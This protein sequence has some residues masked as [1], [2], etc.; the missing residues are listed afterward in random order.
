V[1]GAVETVF[2]WENEHCE[3][4]DLPDTPAHAVRTASGVVLFAADAPR[5]FVSVGPDL[6]HVHRRCTSAALVSGERA[7][8]TAFAPYQWLGG[9]YAMPDGTIHGLVH[10]EYHDPAAANCK[11]GDLSP[12]NPCWY[13]FISYAVSHDGGLTFTQP[14]GA[15]S[16]VAPFPFVWDPHHD[17]LRDDAAPPPEGY[18]GP[19]NVVR[20]PDGFYYNL[21]SRVDPNGTTAGTCVMRTND[22]ATPSS[23]RAWGGSA[24]DL[25]LV[26]P[27][28]VTLADPAAALCT[29]VSPAQIGSLHDSIEWSTYYQRW[30]VAGSDVLVD[31]ADGR[32]KCGAWVSLSDDLVHWDAATLVMEVDLGFA[33]CDPTKPFMSYPALLDPADTSQ[34]FENAGKTPYLYFTTGGFIGSDGARRRHNPAFGGAWDSD[35]VRVQLELGVAAK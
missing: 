1:I 12:A 2:D 30:I 10:D 31:P 7:S 24:F 8:V 21:F 28:A 34:N 25:S 4:L 33:F 22:L 5:N 32:Q 27:Y 17:R 35:L 13:N 18:M 19:S 29:P 16:L 20:A 11:P 14:A 15:A 23:W 3:M 26:N 9:I 6:A